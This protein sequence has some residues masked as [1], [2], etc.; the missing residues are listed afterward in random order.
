MAYSN[1]GNAFSN[2]GELDRAIE[3]YDHA[4]RLNPR[5][6]RAYDNRGLAHTRKGDLDRAIQDFD[7]AVAGAGTSR[8]RQDERAL[9]SMVS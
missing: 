9:D 1:R 3:D 2:K 5:D 4:I 8:I 7:Q 6:V